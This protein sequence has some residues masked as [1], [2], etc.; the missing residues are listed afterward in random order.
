M[1]LASG[2]LILFVGASAGLLSTYSGSPRSI[3]PTARVAA[4]EAEPPIRL[5]DLEPS[6]RASQRGA[7]ARARVPTVIGVGTGE[8]ASESS[9]SSG[10][11]R[12]DP[13]EP[14]AETASDAEI[15]RQLIALEREQERVED[16][17]EDGGPSASGTGRLIWP[18]RGPITSPFGPRWG[19][20]HAGLDIGVSTG[21]PVRAADAGRVV[22]SAPMGAYG[23][24]VCVRHTR[25]LSTCYAHLSRF[26]SRRGEQVRKGAVIAYS[27]NTGASTGPHLHFETRESGKPVDPKSYLPS[28]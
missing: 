16:A 18:S 25:V 24:Y 26:A 28:R 13:D 8:F 17:L 15:R 19:R 5:D 2:L 20:L 27:G 6:E 3:S 21:T 12:V 22:V 11:V 10:V 23:N 9:E 4:P 1:A 14:D 7:P